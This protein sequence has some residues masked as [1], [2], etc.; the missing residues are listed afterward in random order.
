[1]KKHIL[2]QFLSVSLVIV[3]FW[4]RKGISIGVQFEVQKV[5]EMLPHIQV[6]Q[7]KSIWVIHD[8]FQYKGTV[9]PVIDFR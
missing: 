8:Y 6:T 4:Q 2:N 5:K 3:N 1:M 7:Y 9:G